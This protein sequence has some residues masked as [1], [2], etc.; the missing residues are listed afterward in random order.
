MTRGLPLFLVICALAVAPLVDR[1]L[2]QVAV[3]V[4]FGLWLLT[5]TSVKR[6]RA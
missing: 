2:G 4:L 6:G 1:H 3:G 5:L